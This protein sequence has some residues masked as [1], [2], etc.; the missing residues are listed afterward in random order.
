[1]LKLKVLDMSCGRCA[2]TIEK[3]VRSVDSAATV[4]DDLGASTVTV[5][6]TVDAGRIAEAIKLAG[7]PN[8]NLAA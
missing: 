1:M 8:E 2:S 6:T 4:K 5:E 7:Y 3:A